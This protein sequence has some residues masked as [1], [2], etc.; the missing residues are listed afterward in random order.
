MNCLSGGRL[1]TVASMVCAALVAVMAST[2]AAQT[3]DEVIA[4]NIEAQG[5]KKALLGIK[6]LERKGNVAV[7]GSFGQMEGTI[8]EISIPWKKA[9]RGLDLAIFVQT[10]GF[11]EKAAWREDMNGVREIEGEE[12]AQIKSSVELNP[13]VTLAD[14]GAKA[15]KLEDGKVDDVDCYVLQVSIK[16]RPPIKFFIDKATNLIKRSSLTQSNPQFG[17]IEVVMDFGDYKEFG[18]IKLANKNKIALGE[19]LQIETTYTETKVDGK[20]D[21]KIF[22]KPE[23]KKEE[24]KEEKKD[25]AK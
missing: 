19:A 23:E 13:F 24:A 18:P 7:D 15:E 1:K 8:E 20:I 17:E 2:A 22:D 16:D 10:D 6:G 9:R 25:D 11:N 12:A 21:E 14:R 4:K 5:G 3:A